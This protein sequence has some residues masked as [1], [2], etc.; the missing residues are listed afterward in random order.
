[1]GLEDVF[2]VGIARTPIGKFGGSLK[3]WPAP[4]LGAVAIEAALRRSGLDPQDVDEVI[5]GNVIQALVGQNPA[6]QAAILAGLPSEIPSFTV[7]KVCASGMKAISLAAQSI[8][9]GENRVVVAGGMESMSMAPY[10]LPAKWRWG[11]RFAFAGEKLLDVM[12]HDGLTDP[13]T[14]L[15]MGEEAEET[16]KKWGITREEA[17]E[18]AVSSHL[19]AA[20]ATERGYFAREIEPIKKGD[21]V[22]LDRD[23]GI[24]PDTS[25][26]KV[27]RLKPVFRPDGI[28][29]AANASQLS[30][31]AAALVLA[32]RDVVEE[33]GLK[34]IARILGFASAGVE[35]KDFVEAPIPATQ[36][37]LRILNMK[38]E[39]FDLYEHNEAF[40]L[41]SLVVAKGLNIPLERLNV[42]GGAVAIGHPLGE[43]GARIVVTLINALQVKGGRRGLATICHGG[44]GGQSIAV[45]LVG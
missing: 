4:K 44:G 41:A 18:F 21:E 20:D 24:R 22:V 6:R 19:K 42:F 17:D 13:H 35:P 14:G 9:L 36:K 1:M 39:D 16:G 8:V 25:L 27:A 37:L 7:N 28:I 2:V 26:E 12:V 5:M 38:I 32:H 43:S 45:E 23:E 31:G 34:P 15:L 29:T 40:A 10:S 33:K 11:M 30:D 3:D